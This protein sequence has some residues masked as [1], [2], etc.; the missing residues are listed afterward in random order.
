MN[1]DTSAVILMHANE[2]TSIHPI[3][4][5]VMRISYSQENNMWSEW[6]NITPKPKMSSNAL[7]A[8]QFLIGHKE[9][10]KVKYEK[11]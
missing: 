8:M 2:T 10:V 5:R 9:C 1:M 6:K 7:F 4:S 3:A 11:V